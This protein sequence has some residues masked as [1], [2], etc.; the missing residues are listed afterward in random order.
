MVVD[1]D[2][3]IVFCH[4]NSPFGKIL[5]ILALELDV[6]DTYV[7]SFVVAKEFTLVD[8]DEPKRDT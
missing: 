1:V 2:E 6:E 8:T 3:S 7:A 5:I 4:F